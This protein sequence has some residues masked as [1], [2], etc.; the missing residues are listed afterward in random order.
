ML[1]LEF[2]LAAAV[3]SVLFIF[4]LTRR[5]LSPLRELQKAASDISEGVLNR[6][7]RV[8]SHDEIGEMAGS[9]NRMADRIEEQRCV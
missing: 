9:F 5:M 3:I 7:A 1:F 6:R 8:K 2:Y 4:L